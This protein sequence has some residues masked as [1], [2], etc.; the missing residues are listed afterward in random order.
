VRY[1]RNNYLENCD[2]NGD[3]ESPSKISGSQSPV[4]GIANPL[5]SQPLLLTATEKAT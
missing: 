4:E 1:L 3:V 5:S 2:L